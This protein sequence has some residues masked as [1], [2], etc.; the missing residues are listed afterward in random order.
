VWVPQPTNAAA[1]TAV[2]VVAV[3]ASSI[4]VA[5]AVTPVGVPTGKVTKEIRN[6]LPSS[7]KKWLANYMSSKQKLSVGEKVGS[8]F[9]P[10][11]AEVIAYCI[12][13]AVLAFSFSYVKVDTLAEILVV[14]PTIFV[15][16]IVVEFVKTFTLVAYARRIGV[17]TEH[18]LWYFGLATFVVTTLAFR[19]P[20]SSPSR[21]VHHGPKLTT[22]LGAILSSAAILISLAFAGFFCVLLI[23]GF[24]A[25]GSAGLAMCLISAFF[26]T[27]P[28]APMNGKKIFDHKKILWSVLFIVTLVLYGAWLFLL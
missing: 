28:V 21:S 3:G 2:T 26:D 18:K 27:F 10:K 23:S 24:T 20:F 22:R 15:T 8:P 7:V 19:V 13:I 17:W 6:L 4:A 12:S 5:A 11:K 25:I 1:A 14:L 9:V 16:S